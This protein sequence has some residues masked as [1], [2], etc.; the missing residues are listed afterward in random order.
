MEINATVKSIRGLKEFYFVVPEYQREYVWEAD[1]Q[2]SRFLQDIN[3]EFNASVNPRS[4]YFIGNTIIVQIKNETYDVVDGQQRLTTIIITLCAIRDSLKTLV[5]EDDDINEKQRQL[6]KVVE[7][8]LYDYDINTSKYTPRLTLQY[9]ESKDYLDKLIKQKDFT[10]TAT[11]SIKKMAEAYNTVI[12]FLNDLGTNDIATLINFVSYFLVN[13][14]M[15]IIRPDNLGSALKIFE[16]INERGVGLNAMDLLKNLLF[17][18]A[19]K[20][21]FEDIKRIWREMQENINKSGEGDKPLRFLRYFLT[22]RYRN[23]KIMRED[24]IYKWMIEDDTKKIVKYNSNPVNFAK[25]LK[26]AAEKYSAFVKATKAKE[27]DYYYP[28]ITGV[29][30]LTKKTSR[31]HL[32][33]LMALKENI[34]NSIINLLAKNIESL[35]FYYAFNRTLTKYYEDTFAKWATKLRL[36]ETVQDLKDFLQDDFKKEL[37]GQLLTFNQRFATKNEAELNPLARIKYVLGRLDNYIRVN[38]N[39]QPF[40]FAYYQGLQLEHILPQKGENIP[41]EKY[42][43]EFDYD[44]TVG[45]FGNLTLLEAPINQSL[46]FSNDIS[47]NLW[48]EEKKRQYLKQPVLLTST[49]SEIKIGDQTVFNNFVNG[50]LKAFSDWNMTTVDERQEMFRKLILDIWKLELDIANLPV[51]ANP[52]KNPQRET[53]QIETVAVGDKYRILRPSKGVSARGYKLNEDGEFIVLAGSTISM[54]RA[55]SMPSKAVEMRD[56]CEDQEVIIEGVFKEDFTFN[57]WSLAAGVILGVSASGPKEW[58]REE[59]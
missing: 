38:V 8:L 25:E 58:Q 11:P 12:D 46:N 45:K 44:N 19:K 2:V 20:E 55:E 33:L 9:E 21:Q 59:N 6:I 10:E 39:F 5:V 43:K 23:G 36:V 50:R 31:A 42:P 41:N 13:V 18:H 49:L 29:G 54:E 16:T 24:E 15:V 30:Y 56:Y 26:K 27:A 37:D 53:R 14:Q 17:I 48:F 51:V 1:K 7:E 4:N 34:D 22:A 57:S 52:H 47:S 28:N 40:N 35:M 32:V 3:D